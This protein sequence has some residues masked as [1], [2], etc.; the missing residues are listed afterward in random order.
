MVCM[1][2]RKNLTR[3]MAVYIIFRIFPRSTDFRF[4]YFKTHDG[5]ES[6]TFSKDGHVEKIP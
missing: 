6:L 3:K 2:V 5:D 1:A 4:Y